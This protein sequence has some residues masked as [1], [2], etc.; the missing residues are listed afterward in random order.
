MGNKYSNVMESTN[1]TFKGGKSVVANLAHEAGKGHYYDFK[2]LTKLNGKTH[3]DDSFWWDLTISEA[4]CCG[5]LNYVLGTVFQYKAD[6]MEDPVKAATFAVTLNHKMW[7]WTGTQYE[8][9]ADMYQRLYEEFHNNILMLAEKGEV[10]KEW[11]LKYYS[12]VD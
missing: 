5:E 3:I 9:F 1:K 6:C 4:H 7:S 10:S 11:F 8:M 12:L 2:G